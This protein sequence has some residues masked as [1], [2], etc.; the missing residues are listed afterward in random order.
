MNLIFIVV[1][2]FLI[3]K[4]YNTN[5]KNKFYYIIIFLYY[6]NFYFNIY[7]IDFYS[8]NIFTFYK[9]VNLALL[10]GLMVIHPWLTFILYSYI[11]FILYN[12]IN[13]NKIYKILFLKNFIKYT[14]LMLIITAILLGS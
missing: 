3:S 1:F 4:I 5:Y 13:N 2:V 6:I 11:I 12:I 14:C 10:N 7:N 8:G 9:K